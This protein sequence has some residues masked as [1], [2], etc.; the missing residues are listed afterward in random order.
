MSYKIKVSKKN[1]KKF[2]DLK[3][4]AVYNHILEDSNF[5]IK[6]DEQG[7]AESYKKEANMLISGSCIYLNTGKIYFTCLDSDCYEYNVEAAATL[8]D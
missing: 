2:R 7:L 3:P 4:G 5:Y 6:V 1:P 8:I